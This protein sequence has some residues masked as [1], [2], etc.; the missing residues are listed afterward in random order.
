MAPES[1]NTKQAVPKGLELVGGAL[2]LDFANTV[3][4]REGDAPRDW[5][6]DAGDLV[7]WGDHAGV[8]SPE[9]AGAALEAGDATVLETQLHE[10]LSLREAIYR[11]FTAIARGTAPPAGDLTV[12]RRSHAEGVYHATLAPVSPGDAGHRWDWRWDVGDA[13]PV[14][15]ISWR[16]SASAIDLLRT[17]RID[18]LRQCPGGGEGPCNW[19][20]IDTTRGGNRRWCS[21]ADCGGRAKWRRQNARRRRRAS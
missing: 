16:G 15:V 14:D 3:E 1:G 20:F 7:R 13:H 4:G 6:R 11:V 19:L 17:G 8:L 5:I 18:R 21:M 10:A 2:C 9:E 12:V